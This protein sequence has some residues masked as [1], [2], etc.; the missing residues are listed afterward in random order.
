MKTLSL[1]SFKVLNSSCES[2]FIVF[3]VG[4]I[5]LMLSVVSF[6]FALILHY[7]KV[8][9]AVS[10]NNLSLMPQREHARLR[11]AKREIFCPKIG[12][13]WISFNF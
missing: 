12:Y 5:L 11:I 9:L 6:R 2:A 7:H 3:R 10:S 13:S 1:A 4:T 8:F